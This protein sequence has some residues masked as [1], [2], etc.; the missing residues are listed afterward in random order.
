MSRSVPLVAWTA[1]TVSCP[2]TVARRTTSTSRVWPVSRLTSM[3]EI[4]H[5][6]PRERLGDLAI[7]IPV[8]STDAGA[9]RKP[10]MG[11]SCPSTTSRRASSYSLLAGLDR[12]TEVIEAT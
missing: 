12:W 10:N 8:P 11:L 4:A 9:M 7:A 1:T 6:V 2:P 3:A 5:P